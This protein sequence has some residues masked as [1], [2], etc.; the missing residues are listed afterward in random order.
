MCTRCGGYAWTGI[1]SLAKPCEPPSYAMKRQRGIMEKGLFPCWSVQ[2]RGW[3]IGP[4]HK[5]TSA[6]LYH[7]AKGGIR[8]PPPERRLRGWSFCPGSVGGALERTGAPG[9]L[10][11][12]P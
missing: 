6:E 5:L 8:T 9:A 3:V 2:Y 1:L 7:L 10:R 12:R 11:S 4:M